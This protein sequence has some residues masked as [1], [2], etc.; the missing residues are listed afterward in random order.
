V[1]GTRLRTARL[2]AGLSARDVAVVLG[3]SARSVERVESRA[4]VR[5][6]TYKRQLDAVR[7]V[8]DE[9]RAALERVLAS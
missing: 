6:V 2:A 8:L 4:G 1:D 9:R 7:R 5:E 3:I